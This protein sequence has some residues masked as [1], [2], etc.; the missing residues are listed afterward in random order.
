M[1]WRCLLGICTLSC[2]FLTQHQRGPVGDPGLE[3]LVEDLVQE[4][5]G[6]TGGTDIVTVERLEKKKIIPNDFKCRKETPVEED[7]ADVVVADGRLL[8]AGGHAERPQEAV[9]Q[10]GELVHVLRLG[11]RHAEDDLVPLPHAL[12]VRRADVVLD[13]DLPPPPAQPAAHEALHLRRSTAGVS[14][15][16]PPPP[17][18]DTHNHSPF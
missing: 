11:L 15:R 10:D 9:H 16:T 17:P 2:A 13:D 7:G 5:D 3:T 18:H 12:G 14:G 4:H 8:G 1:N 6:L